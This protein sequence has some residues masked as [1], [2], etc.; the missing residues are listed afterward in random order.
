MAWSD[1]L[2]VARDVT[3]RRKQSG[4][5]IRQMLLEA[6]VWCDQGGGTQ[7]SSTFWRW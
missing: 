5:G 6:N 2:G 1:L 4:E 3:E 7:G